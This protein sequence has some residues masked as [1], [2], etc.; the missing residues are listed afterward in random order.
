MTLKQYTNNL[1]NICR[2]GSSPD[3]RLLAGYHDR[4]AR[5][6][7]QVEERQYMQHIR[8][9]RRVRVRAMP[10]LTRRGKIV[11]AGHEKDSLPFRALLHCINHA[12]HSFTLPL[13]SGTMHT[14]E[15]ALSH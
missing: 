8:E 7:W 6:E 11:H 3:P 2:D 5:H 13:L 1:R 10:T 4:V 12:S 14:P 9:V 15:F